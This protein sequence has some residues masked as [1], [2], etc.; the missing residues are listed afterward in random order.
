MSES[1][2]S[3]KRG[4]ESFSLTLGRPCQGC[5]SSNDGGTP[6][7]FLHLSPSPSYLSRV[8]ENGF[9]AG[10]ALSM[11]YFSQM[12]GLGSCTSGDNDMDDTGT[13]ASVCGNNKL[14]GKY[15]RK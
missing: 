14:F 9:L 11:P 3:T 13:V 6:S 5:R 10:D 8:N 4:T 1:N 2:S 12:S 7:S 15:H